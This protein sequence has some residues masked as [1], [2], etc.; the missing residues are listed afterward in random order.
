ML[1]A[2]HRISTSPYMNLFAG[3][4]LLVTSGAETVTSF[5]EGIGVHHG[6]LVYALVQVVKVFPELFEGL[7]GIHEGLEEHE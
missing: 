5:E 7:E 6:V 3:L 2:I 4:A 1:A